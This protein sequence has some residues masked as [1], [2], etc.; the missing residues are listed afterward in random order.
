MEVEVAEASELLI[1]PGANLAGI[2]RTGQDLTGMDLTG[3]I[4][5]GL[6]L[7][8]VNLTGATWSNTTCPDGVNG[9]LLLFQHLSNC[10]SDAVNTPV[11]VGHEQP[12]AILAMKW[13]ARK[14]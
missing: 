5:N 1:G 3:A 13:P 7:T 2:D 6:V 10:L 14:F 11:G 9:L 12:P 4:L 8:S